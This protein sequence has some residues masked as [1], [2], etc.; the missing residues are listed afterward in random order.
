MD[1]ITFST[2]LYL[3]MCDRERE[4]ETTKDLWH[5]EM[6]KRVFLVYYLVPLLNLYTTIIHRVLLTK[7][8]GKNLFSISYPRYS[9]SP[10]LYIHASTFAD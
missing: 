6:K 3:C 8:R 4:R 9:N 1:D 5:L 2:N 10:K 7:G